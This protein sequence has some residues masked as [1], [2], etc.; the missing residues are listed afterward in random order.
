MLQQ[1]REKASSVETNKLFTK[2]ALLCVLLLALCILAAWPIAEIGINDDWSSILTTQAFVQT[3][4][5]VYNGWLAMML[6]WQV[7]W[8]SLFACLFRPDFVG[9]RL[10]TIPIALLTAVLYNAILRNFGLNR[11]HS[12]FGTL[13]LTLSPLFL[14]LSGTYMTDSPSLFSILL[15]LYLCQR[16]LAALDDRQA[17][18]WLAAGEGG[19]ELP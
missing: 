2:D 8:G 18:L 1:A 5:F 17:A 9:I 4:H 19:R 15:C 12:L 6:G 14:A 7:L 3:H 10:S 13:A 16:A 11:A